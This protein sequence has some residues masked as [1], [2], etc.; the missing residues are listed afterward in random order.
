MLAGA[1]GALVK[2]ANVVSITLELVLPTSQ[3]HIKCYFHFKILFFRFL[4]QCS[5]GTA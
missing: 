1:S 4:N 2:K 5:G 3:K